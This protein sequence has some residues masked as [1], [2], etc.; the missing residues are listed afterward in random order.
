MER[1]SVEIE[2]ESKS[3]ASTLNR[4]DMRSLNSK[5]NNLQNKQDASFL[6]SFLVELI[7]NIKNTLG[8]VKTYTQISREKF[9]DREFG[10]YY[11][12][13]VTEDIEKMDMILNSLLNYIKVQKPIR[14]KNTVHN[15]I[16][17]VLKKYQAKLDEKGIRLFKKFEQDL[18]ETIVP[19]EQLKYIL[20]SVLQYALASISPNLSMGLYTRSFVLEKDVREGPALF[21]KDSRHIEI[22][23]VFMGYR[24]P[25]EQE[26]GATTLQKEEP[27]D[28][29]LRFV[30]EVVQRNQGMMKVEGD[31]KKAK[32]LIFLRFPV[33]RRNVVYY[34][35][36]N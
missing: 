17:E 26:K 15:I 9:N 10:E 3:F 4:G 16:G 7:E 21:K 34:Q 31:E 24:K 33:E 27:L 32:T 23:V 30:K 2:T 8:T 5:E 12:R 20:N 18:P 1:N 29:I 35:P 28:L 19:D 11:Y 6:S 25:T 14:K 13:S 36:L 22:A